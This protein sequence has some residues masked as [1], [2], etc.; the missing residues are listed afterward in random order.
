MSPS[1]HAS[2]PQPVLAKTGGLVART[3]V[4]VAL[5]ALSACKTK[6][7]TEGSATVSSQTPASSAVSTA[8]AA[9]ASGA[10]LNDLP[11]ANGL[12]PALPLA[13]KFEW[14]KT[15]RKPVHPSADETYAAFEAAG[16]KVTEKSQHVASVYGAIYCLGAKG[17]ADTVFSLC[18]YA[19]SEEAKKGKETSEKAFAMIPGRTLLV[20]KNAL[21]TVRGPAAG[22]PE[23][24]AII[25]KAVDAFQKL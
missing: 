20:V 12:S 22:T 25:Q 17:E 24:K 4:I 23:S 6:T 15:H 2:K 9:T 18:E 10:S 13:D 3:A 11:G 1:F 16:L 7:K 5:L 14:E 21:L 19:S 8:P